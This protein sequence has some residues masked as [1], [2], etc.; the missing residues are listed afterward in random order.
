MKT[1]VEIMLDLMSGGEKAAWDKI[2]QEGIP[3]LCLG[4]VPFS[5][6]HQLPHSWRP[7]FGISH[8]NFDS[9]YASID[10]SLDSDNPDRPVSGKLYVIRE[11][12]NND[13]HK[14]A[15]KLYINEVMPVFRELTNLGCPVYP[16]ENTTKDKVTQLALFLPDFRP[17]RNSSG[18]FEMVRDVEGAAIFLAYLIDRGIIKESDVPSADSPAQIYTNI[19]R[20]V[21]FTWVDLLRAQEALSRSEFYFK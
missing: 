21:P 13:Y 7:N 9:L 19:K 11:V 2:V 4:Y 1:H 16:I 14:E 10:S 17:K 15:E 5:R 20:G 8:N 12:A 18:K 6:F 3:K